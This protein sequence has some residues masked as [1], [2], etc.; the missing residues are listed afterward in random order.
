MYPC[1]RRSS[2]SKHLDLQIIQFSCIQLSD[3]DSRLLQSFFFF[4]MLGTLVETCLNVKGS[5]VKNL[6]EMLLPQL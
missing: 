5:P 4:Q 3:G 1:S 6:C 2:D